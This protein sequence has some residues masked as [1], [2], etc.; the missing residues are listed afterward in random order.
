MPQVQNSTGSHHLTSDDGNRIIG[1]LE[2]QV[3]E[4]KDDLLVALTGKHGI[5]SSK[6]LGPIDLVKES[7]RKH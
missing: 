2:K 6:T 1:E 5:A 3:R 7:S 4:Y